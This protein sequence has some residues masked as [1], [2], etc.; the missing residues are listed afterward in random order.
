MPTGTLTPYEKRNSFR[1]YV[2]IISY[3][4]A[5]VNWLFLVIF[6][7]SFYFLVKIPNYACTNKRKS[8]SPAPM[9]TECEYGD[10]F[11]IS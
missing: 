6:V 5:L 10:S 8:P 1:V 11:F 9:N 3:S 4:I 2:Y 7:S